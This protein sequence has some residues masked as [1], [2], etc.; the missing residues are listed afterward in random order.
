MRNI[1]FNTS[2]NIMVFM[3]DVNDHVTGKAG[4]ALTITASKDGG[5]FGAITPTV[6]ERGNGWYALALTAAH[7]D[8]LG[9]LALHVTGTG[10]DPTDLLLR[11]TNYATTA[12]AIWAKVLEGA[13]S[14]EAVQRIMLAAL[15]G[16]R[17]GLGTATEQ[18]YAQN[19]T[20]PRITLTPDASG[21]GTP[22]LDGAP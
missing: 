10:A 13:L 11:V 16:K 8:T 21:N 6:T 12:A 2:A 7:T 20:T 15:G 3:T 22:T 19:G 5:A 14:A 17:A 4:L 9:D 18:Y 1:D